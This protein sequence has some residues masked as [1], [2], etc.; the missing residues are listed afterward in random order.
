MHRAILVLPKVVP[1]D[2]HNLYSGVVAFIFTGGGQWY[3]KKQNTIETS[4]FGSEFV[5]LKIATELV[6]GLR[7]KLRM[8]GIP[9]KGPTS[10][11]CDNMSVVHNTTAPESIL[12]KKSNAI[13]YH[14]VR[15]AVAANVILI[16]YETSETNLADILTKVYTGP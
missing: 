1:G 5:A 14:F 11:K 9:I 13:P 10:V 7:Y 2:V 4:T 8:M 12:K 16:S 6:Q 15:E 3:S